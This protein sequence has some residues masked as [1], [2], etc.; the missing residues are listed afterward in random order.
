MVL[1]YIGAEAKNEMKRVNNTRRGK[2]ASIGRGVLET[3]GAAELK[4]EKVRNGKRKNRRGG[5]R[6][7][8]VQSAPSSHLT[9]KKKKEKEGNEQRT[10]N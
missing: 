7:I 10:P 4:G 5:V 2:N 6:D 9:P 8:G 3:K 1:G